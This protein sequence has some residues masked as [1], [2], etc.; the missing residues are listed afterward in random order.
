M[1]ESENVQ[2]LTKASVEKL[3]SAEADFIFWD[4]EIKGFGVKV[5]TTGT[6]SFF[7]QYRNENG[8]MR[9]FTIGKLSDTLTTDQARK[10]AK[11]KSHEVHAGRDPLDE[12]QAR[13]HAITVNKLF[14]LYVESEQFT[15]NAQTTQAV[16]KGRIDRHLRPLLGKMIA[17]RLTAD[18]IVKAQRAIREGK[19]AVRVKTKARGLA[20]V[21]GGEGTAGKCVL[22]LKVAYSWAV[23]NKLLKNN[24]ATGLK[25]APSGTRDTIMAGA[26]EYARLFETLE[27][28]E[29][30]KRI[31]S[32]A[33]DAIRFIALTGARRGEVTG[34][35]WQWVDLATGQ[36][37][38][39]REAHKA[40]RKTGK[41]RIIALPAEA[42]AIIARQPEGAVG[43][44]V[45]QASK[46]EGALSLGK[47]WMTVR[48]EAKL[49]AG[50]GLHGL[51]HSI[52]T[53]LAMAGASAVELME[54][55]G[56]RQV[57]T[58]LRYIHFSE[59]ARSTLAERAASVAMAG[60]TGKTEK[61]TVTKMRGAK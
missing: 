24:P 46:G 18:Q 51:R 49:P 9:R 54:T 4:V 25:V 60:L 19:T 28:M 36:I 40:G 59:R 38:L 12:K 32:A 31:R 47:I 30:E 8:K 43:D 7:Y 29:N 34:L 35:I 56:H 48:A 10:K 44:Y 27:R 52:G 17:D 39:P 50:L 15:S 20:K 42:Q 21:T 33:A 16:D 6:K 11:D 2:K 1:A 58:T 26:E 14:D 41:P 61:A 13:R 53:H 55:L 37:T 57:S 3:Q 45:F 23:K 22:L 5:F